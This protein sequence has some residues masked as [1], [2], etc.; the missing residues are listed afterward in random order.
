MIFQQNHEK[1][2]IKWSKRLWSFV[3]EDFHNFGFSKYGCAVDVLKRGQFAGVTQITLVNR[4]ILKSVFID[5][6]YKIMLMSVIHCCVKNF[7]G[8]K[9]VIFTPKNFRG[10][11]FSLA[12]HR[13][14]EVFAGHP[15]YTTHFT[16]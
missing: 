7:R 15:R 13:I 10:L 16:P 6:S 4:V 2:Y 14:T 3:M 5:F 11:K 8:L 12:Q 1:I 9:F